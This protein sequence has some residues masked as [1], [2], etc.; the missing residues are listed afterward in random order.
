MWG[1]V[2]AAVA[3]VA[4]TVL[5]VWITATAQASDLRQQ[6]TFESKQ[7][8]RRIY[9]ATL[10]CLEALSIAKDD[11]EH[12]AKERAELAV[13]EVR[14]IASTRV[15]GAAR[16]ALRAVL[17]TSGDQVDFKSAHAALLEAM[18]EDLGVVD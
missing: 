3:G 12:D 10:A 15:Q 18:R 7:D 1:T 11:P 5:G 8:K 6:L 4:G 14:L 16:S 2:I 9:A 13:G 17:D